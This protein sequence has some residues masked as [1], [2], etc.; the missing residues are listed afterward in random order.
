MV[1]KRPPLGQHFLVDDKYVNA[2]IDFAQVASSDRV[3]EIGTGDGRLSSALSSRVS[4][5]TSFEKD[6]RL[7]ELARNN[8]IKLR[9]VQVRWADA[10][11]ASTDGYDT[12]V[13]SL[14][15]Y[16]SG[17]FIEWFALQNVPKASLILQ[18]DFVDKLLSAPGSK[19]YGVRSVVAQYC[20]NISAGAIIPKQ[21]FSPPPKVISQIVRLDRKRVL[22]DKNLLI[23]LKILFSFRGRTLRSAFVQIRKRST[24]P[25]RP[26]ALESKSR[27]EKL[28]PEEA[29]EASCRIVEGVMH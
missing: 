7:Y 20:F 11:L 12:V 19:K 26:I 1:M 29:V 4:H 10:L 27:V 15:F 24:E 3:F 28:S 16:I 21:A 14:P 13:S 17:K 5:V 6:Q 8:L 18:K 2:L 25:I 9:N 22:S 23:G